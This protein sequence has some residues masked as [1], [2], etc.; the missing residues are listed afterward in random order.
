MKTL[1]SKLLLLV[2]GGIMMNSIAVAQH[3]NVSGVIIDSTAAEQLPGVTIMLQALQD[4]AQWKGAV[5]DAEGK[6]TFSNV[7]SGTYRL[8][9]TY[10]GYGMRQR[11][12]IVRLADVDI[13]VLKMNQSAVA[14]KAIEVTGTQIRMEQK[15]DTLQYNANAFK[16]NRD[17]TAEDLITK[18]PGI[19]VD[20]TGVKAQGENIQRVLVNGKPFFGDDPNIALKNLPAEI[21]D[22][23]E[24][25][26]R[27]S[28]QSQFTG[29]DDGQTSKTINIVTKKDVKRGEFG[30]VYAG[31]GENGR[32]IAGG[33]I[34]AFK[35]ERQVGIIGLSNNVN[36]QNFSN[37]DL[38]SGRG[39]RGGGGRNNNNFR[40]GQQDGITT[41]HAM[42]INYSNAWKKA[43][44]SGS[45]FFNNADNERRITLERTFI[46]QRDSGLFYAERNLAENKSYNH[47]V[48]MRLEYNIDSAN[49]VVI[50]PALS[51]QRNNSQS[52]LAGEYFN[53][54]VPERLLNNHNNSFNTGYNFSNNVL[55]RHRFKKQGRSLSL[56]ARMTFNDRDADSNLHSID[57]DFTND[58]TRRIDQYSDQFTSSDTYSSDI[59]FT[60]PVGKFSQVQ[61]NYTIS[62]TK[63]DT[64]KETYNSDPETGEN[65][66]LDTLLTNVFK[67]AYL[68]NRGGASYRFNNKKVNVMTGLNFQH[69]NLASRQ[70]FPLPFEL[71]RS[72][73]NVLPE[74]TLN[75]RFAQGENIRFNYRTSTDAPSVSQLQNVVN[76][77]NPL[78]L[79]SGNP[80]LRQDFQHSFTLRYRRTNSKTASS[81]MAFAHGSYVTDHI[82]NATF[83]AEGD[84]TVNGV[85][86]TQRGTQ[87]SYPVNVSENWNARTLVTVGLPLNIIKSN[88]NI[89]T[90]VDYNRTPAMINGEL[91][92]AHN[93]SVSEGLVVSSNLESIDFTLSYTA[94]YVIVNNTLQTGSDNNYFNQ[95]TSLRL[96]WQPWKGFVFTSNLR[97][98]SYSGLGE[99]FNRN[100]WFVNAAIGYKLLK[101]RS[102]DIRVSGFDLLNQNRSITREVSDTFIEDN[103]TN[104]LT[105]YYMLM[106]TYDLRKFN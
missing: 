6:F 59:A 70:D 90:G 80:G 49:A 37:E 93:Y 82:G 4:T 44:L 77:Q 100:I 53:G 76:N 60:E 91:N 30:K 28:E 57:E 42:G 54:D 89:N 29:F 34:N 95:R 78:F 32:Y 87:L 67:N 43:E 73:Q 106:I 16:S 96:T 12:V 25:F 63:S 1:K 66:N 92:L 47:R 45:Y 22:K 2:I 39:G 27:L 36:Q 21:I 31:A 46:T 33:N 17:A 101:N 64:E 85:R 38:N 48:N 72:F 15:G 52:T 24:V 41:T 7:V 19:I 81:F 79:R 68:S 9:A 104:A 8:K 102:L 50:T 26:D 88:L 98:T 75:Y 18:M 3:F 11:V 23:I 103:Q 51:Q 10:I 40:V 97:N 61:L 69:A 14:L 13:G 58:T 105:R 5:T 65:I 86:L 20:D 56:N 55:L 84:T 35:G 94:N 74:I 99:Q 71:Q 62:L 83:I